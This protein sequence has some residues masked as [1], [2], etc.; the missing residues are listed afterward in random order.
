MTL[1]RLAVGTDGTASEEVPLW[2]GLFNPVER[3]AM[4]N[5]FRE[6]LQILIAFDP[7]DWGQM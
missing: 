6:A 2:K 1:T 4:L 5:W 3:Y 7:S